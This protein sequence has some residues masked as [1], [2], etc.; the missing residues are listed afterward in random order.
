[1]PSKSYVMK[2]RTQNFKDISVNL[3]SV[4]YNQKIKQGLENL[5]NSSIDKNK[6]I[7]RELQ[8]YFEQ[9]PSAI[10]GALSGVESN[11]NIYGN[12]V[13][14]QPQIKDFTGDRKPDFLVVTYNSLQLFFNFIE[15]E[16]PNKSIFNG[17][18]VELH[19]DFTHAYNQLKQWTANEASIKLHCQYLQDHL[20][21]GN[22]NEARKTIK[23]NY[24]LV[25][26]HQDQLTQTP[27]TRSTELLNTYFDRNLHFC[28]YS[29]V[30]RD[31]PGTFGMF[32]VKRNAEDDTFKAIGMVPF[33]N[34][35]SDEWSD[36]HNVTGKVDVVLQNP[37][38]TDK[39]KS[40]LI[41]QIEEL[42]KKSITE[43]HK[44]VSEE[45]PSEFGEDLDDLDELI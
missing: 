2:M 33:T 1:M 19:G 3:P 42:D 21:K 22:F 29:R 39:Q 11:H 16:S 14:S 32:S 5:I 38:L 45:P 31:F 25:Y 23:F 28:T 20:F 18:K 8:A 4:N 41:L 13:I 30:L 15:I 24:I 37:D 36:F 40:K 10:L 26:G 17:T 43:I 9:H 34:Y 7:E 12:L 27:S 44:M 35:G 6:L